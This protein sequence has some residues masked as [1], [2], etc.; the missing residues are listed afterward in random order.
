MDYAPNN[1]QGFACLLFILTIK[2]IFLFQA[3]QNRHIMRLTAR[4]RDNARLHCHKCSCTLPVH[5]LQVM[6]VNTPFK[7][8][9]VAYR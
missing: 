5:R 9:S 2:V 6:N 1:D 3:A 4:K 8:L 7:G